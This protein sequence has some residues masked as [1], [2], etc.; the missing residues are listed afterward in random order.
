MSTF[1]SPMTR[2]WRLYRRGTQ[3]AVRDVDEQDGDWRNV[4]DILITSFGIFTIRWFDYTE[5]GHKSFF[6]VNGPK[7]GINEWFHVAV[8]MSED[9]DGGYVPSIYV[10]ETWSRI[11]KYRTGKTMV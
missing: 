7:L 11:T 4:Y 6:N 5:N 8:T 2:F 10:M 1:A 9:D 3:L